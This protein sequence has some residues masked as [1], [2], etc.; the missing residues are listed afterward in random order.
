MLQEQGN[1]DTTL[2][3]IREAVEKGEQVPTGFAITNKVLLYKGRYV[4]AKSSPF[5][6]ILLREYHDSP[7]GGHAGKL[8]TYLRLAGE[9][10]WEGMRRQVTRYVKE[11]QVCQQAKTSNLPRLLQNL[12]ISTQVWEHV[13]MDFIEGLP[14]SEGV[15][16][17]LV[18]VNRL[19]KFG[20]FVA[21]KYPFTALNVAAKFV[22]EV[23]R[24]H[25]FPTSIVSDRDKVFM[26]IFWREMFRLQQT[27]LLRSM[28]YHPQTDGQTEI[29]NK[30]VEAYLRWFVNGQPKR[31]PRWL[32]MINQK[33]GFL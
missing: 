2:V 5:I 19:T 26:S 27:H 33:L 12:P 17:I 23:V 6:P 18:V 16:T 8:K 32:V 25:G 14:K 30:M 1:K 15:D 9:G 31:W 24:L 11:C 13:I 10:F 29:V 4:L 28:A 22:K 21:L 7:L 20:H 3:R